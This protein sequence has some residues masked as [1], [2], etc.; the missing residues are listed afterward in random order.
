MPDRNRAVAAL[1][2]FS[3]GVLGVVAA[4]QT[5]LIGHLPTLRKAGFDAEKVHGS[6]AAYAFFGIPDALLGIAS[7]GVT[8]SMATA[9]S[10]P[11]L[12][13]KTGV[14]L[15]AVAGFGIYGWRKLHAC[16]LYSLAIGAGSAVS[17]GL[18]LGSAR[19]RA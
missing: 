13:I 8:A 15:A 17:F 6:P 16:S 12:A 10:G 4:Y 9:G 18:A 1:S 14:D 2:L 19:R 7:Y 5:G 3:M 11:V